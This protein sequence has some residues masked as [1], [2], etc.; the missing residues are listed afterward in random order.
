MKKQFAAFFE[1]EAA[2][3]GC[4]SSS[5]DGKMRRVFAQRAKAFFY[6]VEI[7]VDDK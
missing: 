6:I 5:S 2:S 7:E 3:A 4:S 1:D